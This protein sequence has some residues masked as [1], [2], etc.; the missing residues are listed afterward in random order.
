MTYQGMRVA[1]HADRRQ[2]RSYVGLFF[3]ALGCFIAAWTARAEPAVMAIALVAGTAALLPLLW[4]L[5]NT[6]RRHPRHNDNGVDE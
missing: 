1:F 4:L 3:A 5:W 6:V 2:R